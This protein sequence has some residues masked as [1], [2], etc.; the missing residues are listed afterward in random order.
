MRR[1][2]LL[3]FGV[4]LAAGLMV[5]PATGAATTDGNETALT[6]EIQGTTATNVS[7]PAEDVGAVRSTVATELGVDEQ[8]VRVAPPG[9]TVEVR[10]RNVSTAALRDALDAAGLDGSAA[11]I[12]ESVTARTQAETVRVVATRLDQ[13]GIDATVRN[14]TTDDGTRGVAIRSTDADRDDVVGN[15]TFEGRIEFVAHF[16]A[17]NGSY[18]DVTLLTN[19][20]FANVGSARPGAAGRPNPYV[21]VTLTDEAAANYS[22]AMREFGFTSSEG[23]GNCPTDDA[24]ADPANASGYCLYTASDGEVIYAAQMSAGLARQFENGEFAADPQF[25]ITAQNM[26]EARDLALSLRAGALPAPLELESTMVNETDESDTDRETDTETTTNG[27]GP[28]F[29]AVVALAAVLAF[30]VAG[31]RADSR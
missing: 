31:R 8:S 17:G 1:L 21:P 2:A 30:A 6:A 9:D 18:R 14:A 5:G 26:S 12:S 20:D 3:L 7:V 15:L 4:V 16:P 27:D 11:T 10:E 19:D 22:A 13:A 25:V 23:I 24:R 28:G 29:T